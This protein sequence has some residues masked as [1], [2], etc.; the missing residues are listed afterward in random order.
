LLEL[1]PQALRITRDHSRLFP[2]FSS[3]TGDSIHNI[4]VSIQ[5][6]ALSDFSL[7]NLFVVSNSW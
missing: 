6:L 7:H 1:H 2:Y 4:S 5:E 3:T